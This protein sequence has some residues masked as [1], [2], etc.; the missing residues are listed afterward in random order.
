M[1]RVYAHESI[2]KK[3][4]EQL[5]QGARQL[6]VGDPTQPETQVGPLIHHQEVNRVKEWVDEAVQSGAQLLTGGKPLSNS[7]FE[8]TV[9]FNPPDAVR[10]SRQEIFGPVVCVYPYKNLN[11]AIDRANQ[12]P[13]VFQSAVFTKNLD[14]AFRCL[15]ELDATAVM[16]NDHT[17]FRVDWMPLAAAV[18]PEPEWGEYPTP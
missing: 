7:C 15:R 16:V 18:S 1:Q 17:A 11:E 4:A 12:L 3:L 5:A 10:I 8:P 6:K 9:L 2:A 13:F 14:T